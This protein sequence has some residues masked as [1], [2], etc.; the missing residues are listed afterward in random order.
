MPLHSSGNP[1]TNV[2]TM[3]EVIAVIGL[4]KSLFRE[5]WICGLCIWEAVVYFKCGLRIILV[6]LQTV[7]VCGLETAFV[8]FC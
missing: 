5:M 4:T 1:K 6:V 8:L 7:L 3:E 2:S